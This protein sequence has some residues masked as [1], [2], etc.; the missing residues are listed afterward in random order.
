MEYIEGEPLSEAIR[1]RA[2]WSL[3]RKLMMAADLCGGLAFAHR[4][5]VIHRDVKPSNLM[6]A[7]G[8]GAVRL[9]D[10]GIARGADPPRPWA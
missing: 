10:F 4:G 2:P 7:N 1:R 8:S 6:V 9:L 3:H 5:G